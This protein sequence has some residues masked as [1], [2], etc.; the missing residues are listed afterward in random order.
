MKTH[1]TILIDSVTKEPIHI[2][3]ENPYEGLTPFPEGSI[4]AGLRIPTREDAAESAKR[5]KDMLTGKTDWC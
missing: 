2:P 1:K 3:E 5:L 4:F